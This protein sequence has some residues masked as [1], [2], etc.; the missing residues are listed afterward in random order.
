MKKI[1]L[2]ITLCLTLFA[3]DIVVFENEYNVLPLEKKVEKIIVGSKEIVNVSVL[4]ENQ[5]S[6]TVLKLFGKKSGNTSIL[7]FYNDK[8][9]ENH[10]IYVNQNL[11]YVQKMINVLEPKVFL[12]RV[13]DGSTVISGEFSDPHQKKRVYS[14]LENAGIDI[15]KLMDITRTKKVNKMIRTK[16]YLVEINNQK[17]EE[18]G[19]VTGLGF[20]NKH[21]DIKLNANAPTGVTFSGFLL[22]NFGEFSMQ[23]GSSV[24]GTLN[25]LQDKGIAKILDDTVLLTTEDKN[26]SF[27]VGGEVYIPTGIRENGVGFPTIELEEKEYG[28]SLV[29][30]TYFMEKDNFMH[31]DI[32]IKDSAFD[33]TASHNVQLGEFTTVPSFVSKNIKTDIVAQSGQV[34][35]LGGRLHKEEYNQEQKIPLLGDIPLLGELFKRKVSGSKQNDLLFFL[36]PEI[37]DANEN[38][39]DTH[40]YRDFKNSSNKLHESILD[41]NGSKV[42]NDIKADV[43]TEGQSVLYVPM[44]DVAQE[45]ESQAQTIEISSEEDLQTKEEPQKVAQE[46]KRTEQESKNIYTVAS[47][48]IFLR[49]KPLDGKK[50]FVWLE[51][52]NF[53]ISQTKEVENSTWLKIK[54]D[55]LHECIATEKELW[56][57]QKHTKEL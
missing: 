2:M 4:N 27:R 53:T 19:G 43:S 21:T 56:I 13:G 28:L 14:V 17:A 10:H 32:D 41:I 8:S 52:H 55:C 11:G 36:V 22:D 18:L 25:F 15:K 1:V 34:I 7:I 47:K 30:T 51:G 50:S 33:N 12:S 20:F 45:K 5:P 44:M 39:N 23:T 35:A 31:M 54:E 46:T 42:K 38:I 26:A 40:F 6:N 29:L 48:K 16:L 49:E 37:V 3:K 9:I 57:S 24:V